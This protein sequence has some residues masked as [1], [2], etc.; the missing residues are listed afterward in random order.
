MYIRYILELDTESLPKGLSA[1]LTATCGDHFVAVTGNSARIV[2]WTIT[3]QAIQDMSMYITL[4]GTIE[5][6]SDAT[7]EVQLIC[8]NVIKATIILS[9]SLTTYIDKQ[10]AVTEYTISANIICFEAKLKLK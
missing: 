7:E 6:N 8:N 5:K 3:D 9:E 4:S 1:N 2:T 10:I